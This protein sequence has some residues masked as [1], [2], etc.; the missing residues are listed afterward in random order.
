MAVEKLPE[1]AKDGQKN[2]ENLNQEEGF[3]VNLK[4]ARQWFNFLFNKLSLTI[5]QIIDED[6]IRHNEL[7]DNLVT[8]VSNKPLSARQ[9]KYLQD[10]KLNRAV[11]IPDNADLNSYQSQGS[12]FVDLDLSAQT[13][14]NSPTKLSFTLQVDV[15]AGVIQ[16]LTT[17]NGAGTQQF[18]R[19]YYVE[20]SGWQKIY[21]ELNPQPT[22]DS[23]DNL[24][25][26]DAKRPLSANQGRLL[27]IAKLDKSGGILTGE[28]NINTGES[29]P[30]KTVINKA[31]AITTNAPEELASII[32]A[33]SFGW[34][35]SEWQ[36]G[37]VRSGSQETAGFGIT[38]SNSNLRFLINANGT[39]NYGTFYSV[40]KV[41]APEFSGLLDG[42]IKAKDQRNVSPAQVGNARM[43]CY[44]ASYSGIRYGN[45]NDSLYGD[46]LAFNGYHDVSGGRANG[47]FLDKTTHR[48]FHFQNNFGADNWGTPREIAYTDNQNFTGQNSFEH[49]I[50]VTPFSL[51][52]KY[53]AKGIAGD[54]DTGWIGVGADQVNAGFLELGTGDDGTEPIYVRQYNSGGTSDESARVT[55]KNEL[56][57]LD[58]S[59]D[60]QVPNGLYA[61]A[62]SSKGGEAILQN[63][64][65][66]YL[67]VNAGNWGCFDVSRGAVP[68]S[69]Q[70]GGTGNGQG[71]APSASKLQVP[72]SINNV[73]FDGSQDITVRDDQKFY[74]VG[75]SGESTSY[76]AWNSKSG[77]YQKTNDGDSSQVIHFYGGGSNPALQIMSRYSNG[78]LFYR[79]ARDGLGFE[80]DFDRIVTE[81]GGTAPLATKLQARRRINDG[82]FDGSDD[83]NI[84]APM[85]F[86]GTVSGITI[87]DALSD[88]FYYVAS[89]GISN[90]YG[91]GILEVRGQGN[92]I[93]QTYYSHQD[94]LH[95]SVAVRQTWGG[96][97]NF[98]PWRNLDSHVSEI[99]PIPYAGDAVPNGYIAMMGQAIS[100]SSYP[101]L[102]SVYGAYLLDLRGEFIR[103][104]DAGRNVDFNRGIRSFQQDAIRNIVGE[105]G[106]GS[107]DHGSGVFAYSRLS[108]NGQTGEN[109]KQ[110]IYSFD[111]SRVVPTASENRPRNIALNY[112]VRAI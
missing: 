44:F 49:G 76:P 19:S 1:F 55:V 3:P 86:L 15:T 66:R 50:R 77:V 67:F 22:V 104:W 14:K 21:S 73:L 63:T 80:K 81:T 20:W 5:N 85:R 99:S 74:A 52:F 23:I 100:Q 82:Y 39:S 26:S 89:E 18:I 103:G 29:S 40:G 28:I 45:N 75:I 107:A 65:G 62:F 58:A 6:Y 13:I 32:H 106:G 33:M 68:L 96:A 95:G 79:T 16:R 60:T 101:I 12:Y 42:S 92:V 111:A 38:L 72:R 88:G 56:I 9:G 57:L 83:I 93:H 30:I 87:N 36:I 25:S 90:L 94:S 35:E 34:Y 31:G 37:N 64:T 53:L 54:N 69:V 46:F 47:L 78:G 105:V 2:T 4:P 91:Y 41:T 10:Y 112:I 43:G 51:G 7:V 70:Y 97:G 109:A 24:T 102:Y 98:T 17:Y 110:T 84:T 48:I 61:K 8:D 27:N 71:I 11:R 108:P 59:G